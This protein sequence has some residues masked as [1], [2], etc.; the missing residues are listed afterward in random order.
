MLVLTHSML[1]LPTSITLT[2]GARYSPRNCFFFFVLIEFK[3]L[4]NMDIF[5]L[6]SAHEKARYESSQIDGIIASF[7]M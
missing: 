5:L 4:I 7:I 6:L 2:F 3:L 1:W